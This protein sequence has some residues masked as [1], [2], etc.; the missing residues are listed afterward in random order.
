MGKK[1][2]SGKRR[3]T[4]QFTDLLRIVVVNEGVW[5]VHRTFGSVHSVIALL[6]CS[7]TQRA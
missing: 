2:G 5:Q 7:D 3:P 6:D 4:E 1:M